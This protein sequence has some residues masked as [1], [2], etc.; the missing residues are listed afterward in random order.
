[1]K[2]PSRRYETLL[3]LYPRSYRSDRG[4]EILGTLHEASS[5]DRGVGTVDLLYIAT[6]AFRVRVRFLVHGLL[7]HGRLPQPV[8]LVTWLLDGLGVIFVFGAVFAHHGPQNP[9]FHWQELLAGLAFI[10]LSFLLLA[11]RRSL[12]IL[13]IGVLTIFA[14]SIVVDSDLGLG[15]IL[16]APFVMFTLLL[17]IGWPRYKAAITS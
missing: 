1:M 4:D 5:R 9:G 15:A 13:V 10:A 3:R 7:G 12:Y 17:A 2:D 11:R 6:H 8:R 14:C 16:S